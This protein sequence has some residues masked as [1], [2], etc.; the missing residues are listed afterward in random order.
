MVKQTGDKS[1]GAVTRPGM[2]DYSRGLVQDREKIVL[3]K[4][5][6]RHLLSRELFITARRRRF[7]P[8]DLVTG[9]HAF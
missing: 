7:T 8:Q 1:A 9:S 5:F 3:V 6:Q 2:D 4:D